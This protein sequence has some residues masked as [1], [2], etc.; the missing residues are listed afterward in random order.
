M[1]TNRSLL[2]PNEL[3]SISLRKEDDY[4]KMTKNE[5]ACDDYD[6]ICVMIKYRYNRTKLIIKMVNYI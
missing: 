3:R 4:N 2:K 6:N 1:N 5:C